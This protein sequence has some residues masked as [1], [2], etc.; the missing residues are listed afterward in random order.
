MAKNHHGDRL[1][2]NG[3]ETL[4][5]ETY[6]LNSGAELEEVHVC[7]RMVLQSETDRAK[8]DPVTVAGRFAVDE[9]EGA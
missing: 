5:R 1:Q 9:A 2:C 7:E 8:R 3:R 6:P 4:R